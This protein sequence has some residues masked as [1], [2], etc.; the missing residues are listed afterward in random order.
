MQREVRTSPWV[1]FGPVPPWAL[2]NATWMFRKGVTVAPKAA[3]EIDLYIFVWSLLSGC[4]M[5]TGKPNPFFFPTLHVFTQ[6]VLLSPLIASRGCL[7]TSGFAHH[8]VIEQMWLPMILPQDNLVWFALAKANCKHTLGT[9]PSS[10]SVL[11]LVAYRW[12]S[13][14]SARWHPSC[15][16]HG[17]HLD[18]SQKRTRAGGVCAEEASPVGTSLVPH[19]SSD[20]NH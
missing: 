20:I 3:P 8:T 1:Q 13:F 15:D 10:I 17:I 16:T 4:L 7:T 12:W 9:N 14:C 2:G 5:K 19:W 18:Q 6:H 11:H